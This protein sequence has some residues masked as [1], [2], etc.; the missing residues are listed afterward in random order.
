MA[1]TPAALEEPSGGGFGLMALSE[2]LDL[3]GGELRL[4]AAPGEGC[5]V[6]VI[7]PREAPNA[8]DQADTD[9]SAPED[10]PSDDGTMG[11]L[12]A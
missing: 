8:P 7:A 2:R 12:D 1:S 11:D 9:N 5:T 3:F 6:T 4:D 10:S